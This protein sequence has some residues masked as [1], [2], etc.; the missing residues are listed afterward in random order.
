MKP[1]A[2]FFAAN[3]ACSFGWVR[4][5]G[6]TRRTLLFLCLVLGLALPLIAHPQ[7]ETGRIAGTVKRST[8]G[9]VARAIVTVVGPTSRS[10]MTDEDGKYEISGLAAGV[11]SVSVMR[12]GFTTS[13]R[14]NVEVK[15]N[16]ATEIPF[17][18]APAS[19]ETVVV[20]ASRVEADIQTA[21]TAVTVVSAKDIAATP[22]ANWGDL[23]RSVPGLNVVQTSARDINL[24]SRQAS[25]TLTNSQIALVDGRT[26]F[27][28][29]Y[30]VVF[31]DLIPVNAND[32]KQI[33]VVRGPVAAIWGPNAAT[34]AVNIITKTPREA[35]GLSFVFTGGGFSRDAGNSA[36]ASAGGFGAAN[37]TFARVINDR[38]S[39]RLSTGYGFSD[40][41]ARPNGRVPLAKSPVDPTVIVGGGSFDDVAYKNEGTR[42]PKFDL[43]VDQEIGTSGRVTYEGGFAF[44]QGIIQ[45]PIGP[46]RLESGSRLGFGR[47]DYENGR[48]QLAI[49]ANVFDGKAPN[50]LTLAADGNPLRIDFKT[51]TYD[52][53]GSYTQL[54]ES[55]HLLNYGVNFRYSTFDISLA[56]N[57]RDRSEVGGYF[58]DEIILGKFRLPLGFRLDKFSN[59]SQP[60]FS[61]RAAIVFKPADKHAVRLSFNRAHR[62]ASAIDNFVDISLI[63][64]FLPLGMI[65]PRLGNQQFPIVTH[66]FG[67][68]DLKAEVLTGWEL[69]YTGLFAK[70]TNLGLAVYLNDSD[71]VINNLQS[72]SA[73]MAAGVEPF[74]TSQNPPPGWPLPP[75][76][77]DRL[78]QEGIYLP[79][80]VQT[81]NYGKVRNRGFE[82]WID[83]PLSPIFSAFANY[84]YQATPQT[85]SA[86]T[87]PYH[88][89]AMSLPVPPRD[90]FNWG[91]NLHSK[92]YIGS[93]SLNH[94]GKSFWTDA[95]DPSFYGFTKSYT[96]VNGDFGVRWA[97]GKVTT[98]IKA[99]NLLNDDIQQHIFGDILKRRIFGELQFGF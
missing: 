65:D 50:L 66:S 22:A 74:Y 31:W 8:G 29:F 87:D 61:P 51:G 32:I 77:I 83:Q 27:S 2:M 24:A 99:I 10:E 37:V 55:R 85:R 97:E 95:R 63:G 76:V 4:S 82:A 41:F 89:P 98:L 86:L 35:P 3:Q 21:P 26:I 70:R 47:I 14:L 1:S 94:A 43:R 75:S 13:K 9:P 53:S 58:E 71:H 7:S 48:L 6:L 67:K 52:I 15:S 69:G 23:L 64:G 49:F 16:A 38:W 78:A 93:F 19:N 36:G 17:A 30:D 96:M 62:S 25:P 33:E 73:L 59:I 81:L 28:D 56:P 18:L 54:V 88:Y 72:A 12:P 5:I 39:Y 57:A 60:I 80:K 68:T 42:Q 46:F 92:H 84:S 34:G 79:A 91:L 20:T 90:R 11:Y 44:S 40:A 45:T